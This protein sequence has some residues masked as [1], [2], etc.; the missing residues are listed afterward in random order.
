M[1]YP[2]PNLSHSWSIFPS[3]R[4]HRHKGE[5][6][7][8]ASVVSTLQKL[9]KSQGNNDECRPIL[10]TLMFA[11]HLGIAPAIFWR[12]SNSPNYSSGITACS[13]HALWF[14]SY[15]HSI[16][17]YGYVVCRQL[18]TTTAASLTVLTHYLPLTDVVRAIQYDDGTEIT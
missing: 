4:A 11:A 12:S 5:V 7:R 8:N 6:F 1:A 16:E 3:L 17:R 13:S 9:R 15:P 2:N 14:Y 18:L 10:A